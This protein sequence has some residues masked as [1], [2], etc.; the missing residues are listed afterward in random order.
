[1]DPRLDHQI[2]QTRRQFFGSAGLRLGSLALA[3][4]AASSA[5]SRPTPT[6]AESGHLPLPHLP[7][8][9]P[10]AKSLI[11]LHMNGGPSQIDL[12][13]YKPGLAKLFNQDLPKTVRGDQRITTMTSKQGRFPVAP[14]M[15][16]FA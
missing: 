6:I 11:Y 15:F 4:L 16:K 14:S 13:D 1:M 8:F 3:Q 7:H 5:T 2:L 9:A 10:R 12:W